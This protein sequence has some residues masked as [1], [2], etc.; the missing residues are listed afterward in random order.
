M[1]ACTPAHSRRP[2][3]RGRAPARRRGCPCSAATA[4]SWGDVA[5]S[6]GR[7]FSRR[8]RAPLRRLAPMQPWPAESWRAE[9]WPVYT[10]GLHKGR[11]NIYGS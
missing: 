10:H 6:S 5:S 1:P 9:L 11:G 2:G 8:D 4:G 3:A 7:R